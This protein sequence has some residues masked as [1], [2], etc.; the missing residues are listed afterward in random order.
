MHANQNETIR[1]EQ[2]LV[3]SVLPER[4]AIA[5]VSLMQTAREL[6][7]SPP[8]FIGPMPGQ[9]A[10]SP[11][12]SVKLIPERTGSFTQAGPAIPVTRD[13]GHT[14]WGLNE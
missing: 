7:R 4:L 11:I 9:P 2:R 5:A 13:L 8:G 12:L 14:Q 1:P 3:P 10:A 6:P